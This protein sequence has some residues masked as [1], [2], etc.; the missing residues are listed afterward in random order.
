[1]KVDSYS[2]PFSPL[3]PSA[4]ARV[5]ATGIKRIVIA[6]DHRVV[7]RGL[8][9]VLR[10]ATGVTVAEVV[11]RG[12]LFCRLRA[13][14]VDVLV[15]NLAFAG[16]GLQILREIRR[17]YPALPVV[18]FSMQNS[19]P[20]AIRAFR[21]GATAY[22]HDQTEP[23]EFVRIIHHIGGGEFLQ[24]AVETLRRIREQQRKEPH[25]L[26]SPRELEVFRY[27]A[28]GHAVSAIARELNL[29]VKTVSTYRSRILQKMRFSTN[30]DIM[31][32]ALVNGPL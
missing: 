28:E 2:R 6:E 18:V 20:F 22:V 32:Y 24:P 16:D 10:A 23:E 4:R 3:L 5:I 11:S 21:A 26:L 14:E 29:S 13:R 27:I 7:R 19:E 9:A 15:M 30:T 1:M 17:L 12:D 8:T 25:E 31:R